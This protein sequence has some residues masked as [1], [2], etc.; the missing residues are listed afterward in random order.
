[1]DWQYMTGDKLV[2]PFGSETMISLR[3][4]WFKDV[5]CQ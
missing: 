5:R 3:H 2:M 4:M 1:M